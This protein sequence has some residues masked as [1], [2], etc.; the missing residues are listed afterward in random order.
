M[1]CPCIPDHRGDYVLLPVEGMHTPDRDCF[2]TC[3]EPRLRDHPLSDPTLEHQVVQPVSEESLVEAE[4]D[5]LIEGL[6]Q[7]PA[8]G[9][10]LESGPILGYQGGIGLPLEI[11]RWI[12][13]WIA[14]HIGKIYRCRPTRYPIVV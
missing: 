10:R 3:P 7:G 4:E 13:W 8:F 2:L 14:S 5:R 1:A 6:D 11:F 9:V 12:I